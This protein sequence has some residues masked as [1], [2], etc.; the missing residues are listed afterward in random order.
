M[1]FDYH[2]VAG[3]LYSGARGLA[4]PLS[5]DAAALHAQKK[6]RSKAMTSFSLVV[7]VVLLSF[8]FSLYILPQTHKKVMLIL[9]CRAAKSIT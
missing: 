6:R 5:L 2:V 1:A 7:V 8:S 9:L 4:F 3:S